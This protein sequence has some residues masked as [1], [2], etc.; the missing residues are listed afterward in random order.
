MLKKINNIMFIS[1]DEMKKYKNKYP[2]INSCFLPTAINLDFK[3][4]KLEKNNV[5]IIG[6]LFMPN[7]REGIKFYIKNSFIIAVR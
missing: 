7:N 4:R 6:S 1:S 3:R 2:A 5:L